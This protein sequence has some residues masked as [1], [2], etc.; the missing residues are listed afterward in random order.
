M[1]R[2]MLR[3]YKT[4]FFIV[5]KTNYQKYS[6]QLLHYKLNIANLA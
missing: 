6:L 2:K 3:L 4:S 5:S 1:R